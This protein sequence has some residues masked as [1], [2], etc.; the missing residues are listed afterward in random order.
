MIFGF[1][2]GKGGGGRRQVHAVDCNIEVVRFL[3]F[4][5][6]PSIICKQ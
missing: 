5:F 1:L 6:P 2:S 3:E 4:L